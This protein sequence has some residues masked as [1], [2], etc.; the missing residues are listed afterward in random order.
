MAPT[1]DTGT[2][3]IDG[4]GDLQV[5]VGP[6]K[7]NFLVCSKVLARASPVFKAMLFGGF[8]E[9]KPT[10]GT[11]WIVTLPE[12]NFEA[13]EILFNVA[14]AQ[15]DRL[16]STNLDLRV[17]Y[18]T[19]L[20]ADKYDMRRHLPWI[21]PLPPPLSQIQD[22]SD[23]GIAIAVFREIGDEESFLNVLKRLC[24]GCRVNEDGQLIDPGG[25]VV[26][27]SK[28]FVPSDLTGELLDTSHYPQLL[29]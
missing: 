23:N 13:A 1:S 26:D 16:P 28:Q 25:R 4:D 5:L 21:R 10:D 12:D 19:L 8:R 9:S 6:E 18:G 11:P 3:H 29:V 2:T 17:F 27:L 15:F 22:F 14:H 7:R 24:L 20:F